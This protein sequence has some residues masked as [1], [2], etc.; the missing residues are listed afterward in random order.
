M[1]PTIAPATANPN[2][3]PSV[4]PRRARSASTVTHASAPAQVI[5]L[6][7]PWT[8]RETPRASG[9]PASANPMLASASTARP[10]TTARRGPTLAARMPPDAAEQR[11]GAEGGEKDPAWNL[12]RP[13]SS[14]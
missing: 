10:A 3:V 13:K 6:E 14:A 1:G 12:L 2:T 8:K 4:W 9:E 5:V 11:A 7:S